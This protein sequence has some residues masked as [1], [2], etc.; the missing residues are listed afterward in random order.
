[1]RMGR[2]TIVQDV[3][4]GDRDLPLLSV[5]AKRG[6]IRRTALS[7]DE[8][9][10]ESLQMYKVCRTNEIVINRMSAYQGA[11][12]LAHEDGVVSPDY[13][14]LRISSLLEPRYA[15]HL[16]RSKPFVGEMSSRVRGIGSASLGTV[17]TP[18]INWSDLA[19]IPID[20]PQIEVQVEIADYLDLETGRIDALIA[21]QE[22]LLSVVSER[23]AALAESVLN[24]DGNN[25]TAPLNRLA[26]VIDC[27]HLTAD[28]VTDGHALASIGELKGRW[29]DLTSAKRTTTE[30]FSQLSEGTRAP[31]EG[32]I[33]FSRNA[34]VGL[35][36]E[37]PAR[38]EAFA[39]GQD[40]SL[41]RPV[42]GVSGSFLWHALRSRMARSQIEQA[43]IGSTFK[44]INVE[45]VKA[46]RLPAMPTSAQHDA[47]R[48]LDDL[49]AGAEQITR[50]V[51]VAITLLRERRQALISAAVTGKIDVRGM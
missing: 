13:L 7:P 43:M 36:A 19:E 14:V 17:R 42:L 24:I 47:I 23:A 9:R 41:I 44:R 20:L 12:G 5:S 31:R 46:I 4:K 45:Q 27:K 28:F 18:R 25:E 35:V 21:K 8:G 30:F 26:R 34:S 16:F 32:D 37:V 11:V 15:E 38:I 39:M 40:V 29:V 33:I 10:A 3:R 50:R 49:A 1:M 6:V 22:Q 2:V 51:S 48:R